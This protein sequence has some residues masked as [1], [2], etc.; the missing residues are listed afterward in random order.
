MGTTH[1]TGLNT[2]LYRVSATPDGPASTGT[3][4]VVGLATDDIILNV[5]GANFASAVASSITAVN[6]ASTAYTIS[7]ANTVTL[8]GTTA[9]S[10][11]QFDVLY[12]DRDKS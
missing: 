11:Y 6:L 3:F 12:L 4:S 9:Y 5:A 2:V 7:A 1:F 8:S 10:G